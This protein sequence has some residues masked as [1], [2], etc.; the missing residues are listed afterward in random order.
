MASDREKELFLEALALPPSERSAFVEQVCGDDEALRD[1]LLRLLAA[2]DQAGAFLAAPT[3]APSTSSAPAPGS[4][5]RRSNVVA[6]T[7]AVHVGSDI[8]PYH[9]ESILGEG[10]FGRVFLARQREPVTRI[11]ALKILKAGLDSHAIVA[12]FEAERQALAVMDHPSVARVFDGGETASGHPYFVMEYVQGESIT[13]FC[14][15]TGLS[16]RERLALFEQVCL[17]VQHAHQ[18]GIIH[19][20]LKPS[21]VLVTMIDG[22]PVPKV[23]DF[24]IAKAIGPQNPLATMVTLDGHIIG[25]PAYMSPEQVRGST[26]MDT[27]S[28]VYTLGILLYELLTGFLPFDP[29]RLT[30]RGLASISDVICDETPE[31]P[32]SRLLDCATSE[33][34]PGSE[35]FRLRSLAGRVRGDLDW[36][37][38]RAL[39]KEPARRYQTAAALAA[40]IHKHLADQP[41]D[42]GPPSSV[43]RLRKF[44][45]RHRGALVAATVV[46]LA[47]VGAL[48]STLIAAARVEAQRRLTAKELEKAVAFAGLTTGMLSGLDPAVAR[49]LDTELLRKMLADAE[50]GLDQ[51]PPAYPEVEA[52][53]RELL[54]IAREKIA[55]LP[56]AE[57]QLVR[58]TRL[59]R[60]A[61]GD[62]AELTLRIRETL[63][64]VYVGMQ[65]LDDASREFNTVLE[66]R[67]RLL[68][69]DDP[70]LADSRFEIAE[71]DRASGRSEQARTELVRV[72]EDRRRILGDR[73]RDTMSARNSLASVLDDLGSSAEA[74]AMFQAVI[75]YQLEALGPEHPHTL[76]TQNNLAD[77]L[78]HLGRNEEAAAILEQTLATKRKILPPNH[79]SL[80]TALNNLAM[81]DRRL[82]RLDDAER[83]IGEAMAVSKAIFGPTDPRTLI[84]TSNVAGIMVRQGHAAE[85]MTL[86]RPALADAETTL[87]PDHPL[88]VAMMGHVVRAHLALGS[89]ADAAAAGA[90]L[91]ARTDRALPPADP[92]RARSRTLWGR[93]LL[94]NNEPARARA[95]LEE[96]FALYD[97]ADTMQ[98]P[99]RRETIELLVTSCEALGDA[100][101]AA[102]WPQQ[103]GSSDDEG[104]SPDS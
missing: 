79:P 16:H 84:L 80:I 30:E 44:A 62:D 56:L 85:A 7:D 61:L 36:I 71:I 26:V 102:T 96:A 101:G 49:G 31:K 17:A 19:R 10:G 97:A 65:R 15:R 86:L 39:E 48:V 66:A 9:L 94:A 18:K 46:A 58:A 95:V 75:A 20:D 41:V 6:G 89:P 52:E 45:R 23:I 57:E 50:Q 92:D 73:H 77:A 98:E 2:E 81:A 64:K 1:R 60:S 21:N 43:Y 40:D 88:T 12:R 5:A 35:R 3:V 59:A 67:E 69:A 27:R 47:I 72:V 74:V 99:D 51:S 53:M 91:V 28:D 63:G 55:D 4:T 37:V 8:G 13:A 29:A 82:G 68:P 11:V 104:G 22:R 25:T 93:A 100:E 32:S 54:G 87:G 103:L 90:E 42:A 70:R 14:T 38:M 34:L 76:A 33:T 24:G 83:L 78:L